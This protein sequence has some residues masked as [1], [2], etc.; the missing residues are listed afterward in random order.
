MTRQRVARSRSTSWDDYY[1]ECRRHGS[2]PGLVLCMGF[3]FAGQMTATM[4]FS[5]NL[6][7]L[8]P[9]SV[10]SPKKV[11]GLQ[12]RRRRYAQGRDPKRRSSSGLL[13]QRNQDQ[14]HC[15][16]H[17]P[18]SFHTHPKPN[19]RLS[20]CNIPSSPLSSSPSAHS[21]HPLHQYQ[22]QSPPSW[23][24]KLT[25]RLSEST[26]LHAPSRLPSNPKTS[27][28]SKARRKRLAPADCIHAS[29]NHPDRAYPDHSTT[30]FAR[31]DPLYP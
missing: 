4:A 20:S 5:E 1:R 21:L 22:Y 28:P 11:L 27:L 2:V 25:H 13:D 14:L 23:L 17:N 18:L 31:T 29:E 30:T 10:I 15:A 26:T 6:P 8:R 12:R 7:R 19:H 24:G 16:P 9:N 3:P